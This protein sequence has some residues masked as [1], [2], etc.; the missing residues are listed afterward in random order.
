[1]IQVQCWCLERSAVE[2]D[3]AG[4]KHRMKLFMCTIGV[5]RARV[6][7]GMVNLACDVKRRAWLEAGAAP[8]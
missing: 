7:I 4:Q 8:A 6:T 3:F 2:H 1:M 5:A